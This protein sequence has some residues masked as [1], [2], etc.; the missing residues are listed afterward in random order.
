MDGLKK[1]IVNKF[2]KKK[3][4]NLNKFREKFKIKN[5]YFDWRKGI[6]EAC[7]VKDSVFFITSRVKDNKK[8]LRE[9][10]KTK[11]ENFYR[12]TSIY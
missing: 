5:I 6:K 11:K 3:S 8:I 9:C 2:N 7:K 1:Y 12:K 4:K 10:C